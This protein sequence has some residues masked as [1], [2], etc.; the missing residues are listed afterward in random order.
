MHWCRLMFMFMFEVATI[1]ICLF[2]PCCMKEFELQVCII[3]VENVN[4]HKK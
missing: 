2:A 4:L 1:S 3:V